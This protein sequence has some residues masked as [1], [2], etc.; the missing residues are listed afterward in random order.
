MWVPTT[1]QWLLSTLTLICKVRTQQLSIIR[2][3][4]SSLINFVTYEPLAYSVRGALDCTTDVVDVQFE[5]YWE[6]FGEGKYYYQEQKLEW[7]SSILVT[8]DLPDPIFRN[9]LSETQAYCNREV[10]LSILWQ[11]WTRP[12]RLMPSPV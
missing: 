4:E 10:I 6:V 7:D 5:A 3:H 2:R 1:L 11:N 8:D 9:W 12:E